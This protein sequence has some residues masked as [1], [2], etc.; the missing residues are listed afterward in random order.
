ML[1]F[2]FFSSIY[3]FYIKKNGTLE[4]CFLKVPFCQQSE[5]INKDKLSNYFYYQEPPKL[6][7][8]IKDGLYMDEIKIQDEIDKQ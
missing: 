6:I 8:Q 4:I 1:F 2:A 5:L 7:Q 3:T